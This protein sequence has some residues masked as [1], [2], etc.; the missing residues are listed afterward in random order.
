MEQYIKNG[1]LPEMDIRFIKDICRKLSPVRVDPKTR[2]TLR[3]YYKCDGKTNEIHL[4]PFKNSWNNLPFIDEDDEMQGYPWRDNEN[5]SDCNPDDY[6]IA[7]VYSQS[8][9]L[10]NLVARTKI[11]AEEAPMFYGAQLV[12]SHNLVKWCFEFRRALKKTPD[13][14]IGSEM[15]LIHFDYASASLEQLIIDRMKVKKHQEYYDIEGIV[16]Q[17]QE[18]S[19]IPSNI[20]GDVETIITDFIYHFKN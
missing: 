7:H 4:I 10:N 16:G 1:R 5:E 13:M 17:L 11:I 2:V 14:H 12:K 20:I 8:F 9:I 18:S 15:K 3:I 6:Y 19:N